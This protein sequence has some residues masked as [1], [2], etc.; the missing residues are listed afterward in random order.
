MLSNTQK[1]KSVVVDLIRAALDL[2]RESK[3]SD[4][5]MSTETGIHLRYRG[6]MAEPELTNRQCEARRSLMDPSDGKHNLVDALSRLIDTEGQAGRERH[7]KAR[8]DALLEDISSGK[9]INDIDDVMDLE[10]HGRWR[11]AIY[12]SDID[13]LNVALRMLPSS[14]PTLDELFP[15]PLYALLREPLTHAMNLKE[16]LFLVTGSTGSGKSSTLAALID[17]INNTRP[18]N[19]LTAEDPVEFRHHSNLAVIRHRQVGVDTP[20]FESALRSA[21]RQDPDIIM[22]G[23]LRDLD[24]ISRALT[25]AETGHLVLA[26]LHSRDVASTITR[27]VDVFPAERQPMVRSQLSSSLIGIM[28]Q[29]L[30]A[31]DSPE[32]EDLGGRVVIP[33]VA[34]LKSGAGGVRTPILEGRFHE[35]R[36]NL[37]LIQPTDQT[38]YLSKVRAHETLQRMGFL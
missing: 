28:S 30:V 24:T 16:G 38:I 11:I 17:M 26:T 22:L 2:A 19:I 12:A 5:H 7:L 18:V 37:E 21:M 4:I 36:Q 13:G 32:A 15:Q 31:S 29:E 6:H 8:L 14:I 23:E 10:G 35:I 33:E 3:A 20:T 9:P 34:I 25:A 1:V 27:L